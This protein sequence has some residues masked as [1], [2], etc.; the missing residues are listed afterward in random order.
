MHPD[1][2][3]G[4]V[5]LG[6]SMSDSWRYTVMTQLGGRSIQLAAQGA[7]APLD[8]KMKP[9]CGCNKLYRFKC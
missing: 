1:V 2:A 8:V 4:G 5:T 7:I 3:D 9:K 6:S